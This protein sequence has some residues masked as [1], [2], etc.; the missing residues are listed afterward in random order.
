MFSI[1]KTKLL[2]PHHSSSLAKFVP[3]EIYNVLAEYGTVNS[4]LSKKSFEIP[5]P[6]LRAAPS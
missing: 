2:I 3:I 1:V 6:Q 5:A 4:I